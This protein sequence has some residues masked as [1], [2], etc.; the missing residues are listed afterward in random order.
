MENKIRERKLA[1]RLKDFDYSTDGAYFIT[2]CTQNREN[3][4]GE[5]ENEKIVLN[6]CGKIVQKCWNDLPN[7]YSN[8]RLDEFVIMPNHFHGI[9]WIDNLFE[10]VG[11][12]FKPVPTNPE[13]VPTHATL[14]GLSEIIRGFKTFSSR[15]INIKFV[16][17]ST[18]LVFRW[19]RS[20]Y[21][22]IIRDEDELN[23][24]RDYIRLNPAHWMKD[25]NF[26][27]NDK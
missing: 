1:P 4:F 15:Q 14:H 5:I 27:N 8:C 20:F 24:I 3:F 18:P 7:H 13:P 17:Q 16:E 22:H 12:G 11:T 21:D 19:Q 25:K 26:R 6:N 10:P 9:I 23:R 2:T